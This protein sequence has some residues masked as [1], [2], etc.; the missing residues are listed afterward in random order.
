PDQATIGYLQV[1][2][3]YMHRSALYALLCLEA[4]L[5]RNN[6]PE[7]YAFL[8]GVHIGHANQHPTA[9]RNLGEGFSNLASRAS[10][11]Q[12]HCILLGSATCAIERGYGMWDN[13]NGRV[14]SPCI[15]KPLKL[16]PLTDIVERF[17]KDHSILGRNTGSLG[18]RPEHAGITDG[19][20][21]KD[22]VPP[23]QVILIT[24]SPYNTEVAMGAISFAV[25]SAHQEIRTRVVFIEDGVYAL[26]GEQ[27]PDSAEQFFTLQDMIDS[28]TRN[29]RLEFFAHQPSLHQRGLVKNRKFNA[30]LDINNND[31]GKLLFEPPQGIRSRYQRLLFF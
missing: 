2:S 15:I 5:D 13:G 9:F 23:P 20:P 26:S 19:R 6:D 17:T 3:P 25:A 29:D 7:L 11:H 21:V 27:K 28:A 8:D 22:H 4:A 31:L 10:Q 18:L 30:V 12:R 14:I 16:R 1:Q 24:A